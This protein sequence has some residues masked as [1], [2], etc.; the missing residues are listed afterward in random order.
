MSVLLEI[1]SSKL[2]QFTPAPAP[3]ALRSPLRTPG[4]NPGTRRQAGEPSPRVPAARSAGR[5]PEHGPVPDLHSPGRRDPS[6]EMPGSVPVTARPGCSVH[7][8][9]RNAGGAPRV[10]PEPR[11]LPRLRVLPPPGAQRQP[12]RSLTREATAASPLWLLSGFRTRASAAP[13]PFQPLTPAPPARRAAF[14][15]PRGR[16]APLTARPPRRP[17]RPWPGRALRQP[18]RPRARPTAGRWRRYR[19]ARGSATSGFAR[20]CD[21]TALRLPRRPGPSLGTAPSCRRGGRRVRARGVGEGAWQP[22][23]EAGRQAPARSGLGAP[24]AR[25]DGGRGCPRRKG[26]RKTAWGRPPTALP[27]RLVHFF[28]FGPVPLETERQANRPLPLQ[29][30]NRQEERNLLSSVPSKNLGLALQ[31]M[32]CRPDSV[33]WSEPCWRAGGVDRCGSDRA[34]R[35]EVGTRRW[36]TL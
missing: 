14:H 25:T 23:R 1:R 29:M 33:L 16:R 4:S 36:D 13:A 10:L 28:W 18:A 24:R 21:R 7:V 20:L 35:E 3:G 22:P 31:C 17:P 34:C 27:H 30:G 6:L 32:T 11:V 2:S 9:L 5:G 19:Q 12:A 26:A 15:P 8:H